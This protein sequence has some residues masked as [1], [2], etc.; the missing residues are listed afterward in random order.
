MSFLSAIIHPSLDSGQARLISEP[1]TAR[2]MPGRNSGGEIR[3][4]GVPSG[5]Y[6]LVMALAREQMIDR[7]LASDS[8]YNGRFLTGVLTTGIYCLPS[9]RARKPKPENVRFFDSPRGGAGGRPARLQALPAGRLLRPARP[10]PG[11]R[12]GAGRADAAATPPPS[13]GVED[14]ERAS[15]LGSSK[16]HELFR[17]HFHDDAGPDPR[18]RP[19]GGRPAAAPDHRPLGGR[20]GLRGRLRGALHLQRE[21]PPAGGDDPRRVPAPARGLGVPDRPP[22]LLLDGRPRWSTSG[23]TRRA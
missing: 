1:S 8:A 14:L 11:D 22:P 4:I 18:P 5:R 9:C 2:S 13:P 7:M 23:G 15:G 10:G 12:R 17:L 3:W 20:R 21:L 6:I 19:G 16:L